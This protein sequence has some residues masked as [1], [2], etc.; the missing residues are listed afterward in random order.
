[1][2][3]TMNN[4]KGLIL[5]LLQ[6]AGFQSFLK[7]HLINYQHGHKSRECVKLLCSLDL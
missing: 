6:D 5:Q 7:R 1:M 3:M 2:P 4:D